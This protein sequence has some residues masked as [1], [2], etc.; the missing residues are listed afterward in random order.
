VALISAP[1]PSWNGFKVKKND[2]ALS[3][4]GRDDPEHR[5]IRADPSPA[6][7]LRPERMTVFTFTALKDR[8]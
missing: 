3:H 6:L 4:Y 2:P 8:H 1:C 7:R 5:E